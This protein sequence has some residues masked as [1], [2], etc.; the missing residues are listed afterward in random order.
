MHASIGTARIVSDARLIVDVWEANPEF[1]L[2]AVTKQ[3]TVAAID[4]LE[5][6]HA[7]V[8][9]KRT[10][11]TALIDQRDSKAVEV[12]QLVTRARSGIRAVYGP[13]SY[14]YEQAGGTRS[15][16]RQARR[17]S[18]NGAPAVQASAPTK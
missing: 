5:T 9:S 14:Q 17:S 10:E 11:L 15:S 7:V 13:D 1:S 8:E 2:G 12:S 4:A 3:S 6:A 16:E 18:S